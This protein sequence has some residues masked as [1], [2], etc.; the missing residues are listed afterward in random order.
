MALGYD[1]STAGWTFD[2]DLQWETGERTSFDRETADAEFIEDLRSPEIENTVLDAKATRS[3]S[4]RGLHMLTVGAQ[5]IDSVLTDQNPGTDS[6]EDQEFSVNQTAVFVEDEWQITPSVSLTAGVRLNRHEEYD[7]NFTPRLYGVWNA[8]PTLT[9]KGGVSTGFRPPD[10]R[11]IA[12]GYLYTTGGGGCVLDPTAAQPCGVI[13][14]DPNLR[15]ERSRNYE[16]G[17][18]YGTGRLSLGAT[19]FY[20]E[21]EDKITNSRVYNADGS[22]AVYPGDPRYTLFYH[23]NIG[24]ARIRGTEL[25]AD[26]RASD[27]LKLRATYTQTDSEQLNGDYA[28]FPLARTPEHMA[29]LRLD[30]ETRLEG[31]DLWG[32]AT[33]HGS[34]VNAGLR[35]GSNGDPVSDADG[36][37]VARRYGSYT[38]LDVGTSYDVT[39]SVTLNA[40][41][42]NVLDRSIEEAEFG[43]TREGRSF[44]IGTTARF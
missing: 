10:I 33:F 32:E 24:E 37:V 5:S 44:W 3:L 27:R 20:N 25:T 11:E 7:D 40:A 18:L 8:T 26:W 19:Y 14:G 42:Y 16:L 38:T 21:L 41:I 17:V 1:G 13:V 35:V 30:H 9:F 39:D 22:F 36:K 34:E 23:Y 4:F 28:G 2:V 31:L 29:S 43:T 6:E 15:A 12:P